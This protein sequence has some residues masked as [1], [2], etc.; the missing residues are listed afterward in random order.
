M[1]FN[2]LYLFEQTITI[3]IKQKYVT[4]IML[5]II[6]ISL[7]I[8]KFIFNHNGKCKNRAHSIFTDLLY[9][10]SIFCCIITWHQYSIKYLFER[11]ST[12]IEL[13]IASSLHCVNINKY[14]I[15]T[16]IDRC[17]PVSTTHTYIR[18]SYIFIRT[19]EIMANLYLPYIY[20]PR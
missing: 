20:T 10:V 17:H 15:T 2:F 11:I 9:L 16:F 18:Y 4:I 3:Y 6:T 14:D 8:S 19:A 1:T 5:S 13:L 12:S 7:Y